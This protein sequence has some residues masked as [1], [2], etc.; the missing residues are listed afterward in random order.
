MNHT[1]V[2]RLSF[3]SLGDG[4]AQVSVWD[5]WPLR[6]V[7]KDRA[8]L[9]GM[10][11]PEDVFTQKALRDC[12]RLFWQELSP[13]EQKV[14]LRRYEYLDTTAEIADRFGFS[15]RKVKSMLNR[16]RRALRSSM[17]ASGLV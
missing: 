2:S 13:V 12:L 7:K 17:A 16:M 4:L 1:A 10:E 3:A 6:R 11:P 9:S 5:K 14:F 15:Q 8:C